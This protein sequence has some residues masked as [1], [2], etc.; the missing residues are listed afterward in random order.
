MSK[1][2][3]GGVDKY[4]ICYWFRK[5]GDIRYILSSMDSSLS[6]FSSPSYKNILQQ[7][8]EFGDSLK[9]HLH[10]L[11]SNISTNLREH[12]EQKILLIKN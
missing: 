9:T 3:S 7:I 4:F 11:Q 10:E 12:Y 1:D 2:S 8:D 6:K 5:L